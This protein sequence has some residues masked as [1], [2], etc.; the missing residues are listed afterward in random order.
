MQRRTFLARAGSGALA[1]VPLAA[2]A[3]AGAQSRTE[4]LLGQSAVLSGPLGEQVRLFNEGA[5]LV[6]DQVNAAGGVMGKRLKFVSIDDQLQPDKAQAAVRE[7][8]RQKAVA[9]FGCVGTPTSTAIEPLLRD[10]GVPAIGGYAVGDSARQ[11]L[12]GAAYFVRAG[13]G[14]EA[15]AIAQHVATVGL[16]RVAVAHLANPGGD[17]ALT[18]LRQ[19]LV[20]RKL[21]LVVSSAVTTDGLNVSEATRKIG[22]LKPDA[23]VMFLAGPLAAGLIGGLGALGLQPSYYGLSIVSGEQ[24]AGSLGARS[25]GLVLSQVM[26]SPSHP[27]EPA[28]LDYRRLA[29]AA[30]SGVGYASFE[31]YVTARVMVE[32]LYRC[33]TDLSPSRL[34]TVMTNMRWRHAGL[35]LDF[36]QD[37]TGSRFV[38]LVQLTEQGRY[39]R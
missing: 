23:V 39:L 31:G 20:A 33:S 19:A 5:R 16:R 35:D 3:P 28:A 34:H 8:L 4:L 9:L 37:G 32:A 27:S 24:V 1:T 21:E 2:P 7:L 14:R 11:R 30:K 38:E 29:Q 36:T 15:E 22:A 26:P 25:R 6:F 12:R 10:S 18:L 17:E 13:Y